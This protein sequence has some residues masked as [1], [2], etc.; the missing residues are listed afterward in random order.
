M[1]SREL[2][3]WLL[4]QSCDM[5][6]GYERKGNLTLWIDIQ[7]SVHICVQES[8]DQLGRH[9]KSRG[10]REQVGEKGAI[11]PAKVSIGSGLIFPGIAPV[12]AGTNDGEW[13]MDNCCFIPGSLTQPTAIVSIPQFA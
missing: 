2:G 8:A 4:R 6:E 10:D 13:G 5:A 9:S 12:G 1:E 11:I 7:Q 3:R